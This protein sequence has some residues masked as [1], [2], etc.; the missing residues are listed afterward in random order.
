MLGEA[1]APVDRVMQLTVASLGGRELVEG[2]SHQIVLIL[3]RKRMTSTMFLGNPMGGVQWG[4][5]NPVA[6]DGV[7]KKLRDKLRLT[8]I[9]FSSRWAGR[10]LGKWLAAMALGA[11]SACVIS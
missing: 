9:R 1:P 10:L 4:V 3:V 8:C 5:G 11:G 2:A 7:P 6:G